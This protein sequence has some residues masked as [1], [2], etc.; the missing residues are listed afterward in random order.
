MMTG[1][2]LW[3]DGIR[4]RGTSVGRARIL[5]RCW[6]TYMVTAANGKFLYGMAWIGMASI[7]LISL[8]TF[9]IHLK[10]Q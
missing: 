7:S 8:D 1:V 10:I 3:W 9:G 2:S 4:R 6:A 5:G